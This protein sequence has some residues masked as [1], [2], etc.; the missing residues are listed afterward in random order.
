M[1]AM[2]W[3]LVAGGIYVAREL[4]ESWRAST[5]AR[6]G[7]ERER[8][9]ARYLARCGAKVYVSLG[10]RGAADITAAWPGANKW[11]IQVKSSRAKRPRFP[12]PNERKRL[13]ISAS[14]SKAIPVLAFCKKTATSWTTRY[15]HLE[16]TERLYPSR[17]G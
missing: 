15:Y 1:A 9:V 17:M 16:T 11:K 2:Q 6:T 8:A 14:R 3:I 5:R 4:I 7:L 13:K 12:S 10:S